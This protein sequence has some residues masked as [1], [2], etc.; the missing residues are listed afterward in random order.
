VLQMSSNSLG[1]QDR[2]LKKHNQFHFSAA[3]S[4]LMSNS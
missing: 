1:L 2:Q 3:S 4:S